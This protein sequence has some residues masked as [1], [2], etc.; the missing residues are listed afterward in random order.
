MDLKQ[1]ANLVINSLTES[2]RSLS[3]RS[4]DSTILSSK[5][6]HTKLCYKCQ[7]LDIASLRNSNGFTH[8]TP[9]EILAA[10]KSGCPLCI[11]LEKNFDLGPPSMPVRLHGI[12]RILP[13]N[14]SASPNVGDIESIRILNGC[15]RDVDNP[16]SH[17]LALLTTAVQL[18]CSK[19][20]A[21]KSFLRRPFIADFAS[22]ECS[23]LIESWLN[24]CILCHPNCTINSPMMSRL[25][26]RV[27][28]VGAH[29]GLE[30]ALFTPPAGYEGAY[31]ALSYCWGRRKNI[32]LAKEMTKLPNMSVI[33]PM[34]VLPKNLARR[35]S[36]YSKS[37][38]R[39]P[40]DRLSVY[41]SRRRRWGRLET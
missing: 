12:R 32:L 24:K 2:L 8:G 11:L 30:P 33:F 38:V 3:L 26:T 25:P 34:P 35:G 36:D 29:D 9:S 18:Y 37:W 1:K 31:I 7:A 40:L 10:A 22:E 27:I 19:D 41:H 28:R 15:D 13:L 20:L 39:V 17:T 6:P 16:F 5:H 4:N 23:R 21:A 14:L